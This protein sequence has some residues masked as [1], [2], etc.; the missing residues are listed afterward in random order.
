MP[1]STTFT[2]VYDDDFGFENAQNIFFEFVSIN[3]ISLATN[4]SGNVITTQDGHNIEELDIL[5]DEMTLAEDLSLLF[6]SN[7]GFVVH[8]RFV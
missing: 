2:I 5:L 8:N 4:S 7:L 1:A 6:D 3:N